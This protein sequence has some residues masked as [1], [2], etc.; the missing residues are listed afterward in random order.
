MYGLS[1]DS[2]KAYVVLKASDINKLDSILAEN[3]IH[4]ISCGDLANI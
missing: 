1:K 4:T 3:N 2:E